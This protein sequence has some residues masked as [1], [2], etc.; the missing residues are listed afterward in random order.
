MAKVKQED[1]DVMGAVIHL[2]NNDYPSLLSTEKT[3]DWSSVGAR[4]DLSSKALIQSLHTT[5]MCLHSIILT[6]FVS[7]KLI[8]C[9]LF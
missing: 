8:W 5:Y 4:R 3:K 9:Q 7:V 1:M 2:A 6:N